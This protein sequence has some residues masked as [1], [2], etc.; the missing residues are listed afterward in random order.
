MLVNLF[1]L[2][3]QASDV[4]SKFTL[5]ICKHEVD[6]AIITITDFGNTELQVATN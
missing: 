1:Q 2:P 4:Q 3:P 6:L 5:H